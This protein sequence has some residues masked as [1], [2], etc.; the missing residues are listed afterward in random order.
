MIFCSVSCL[1]AGSFS[2]SH[3]SFQLLAH[4]PMIN[5]TQKRASG[6][7]NNTQESSIFTPWMCCGKLSLDL[8][9]LIGRISRAAPLAFYHH[10]FIYSQLRS[11][12]NLRLS[13]FP[14]TCV[15]KNEPLSRFI[16]MPHATIMNKLILIR[17]V[18][19]PN[20]ASHWTLAKHTAT[21]MLIMCA[22]NNPATTWAQI[23]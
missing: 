18:N 22:F 19:R 16:Y 21:F 1:P 10:I 17:L 11:T 4:L 3:I 12:V 20:A 9:V 8:H 7:R 15:H 14:L 5:N 13:V 23:R 2:D 6:K